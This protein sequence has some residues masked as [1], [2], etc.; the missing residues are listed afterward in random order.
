[1]GKS[2]LSRFAEA[3]IAD[4]GST[5]AWLERIVLASRP[6][7]ERG[8]GNG[9]AFA[10]FRVGDE[11]ELSLNATNGPQEGFTRGE[12]PGLESPQTRPAFV[13]FSI[14]Q[15]SRLLK[16]PSLKGLETWDTAMLDIGEAFA[17]CFGAGITGPYGLGVLFTFLGDGG[18]DRARLRDLRSMRRHLVSTVHAR[19]TISRPEDAEVVVSPDGVLHHSKISQVDGG[20]RALIGAAARALE[21]ARRRDGGTDGDAIWD[22][23]LAGGWSALERVEN[24]GKRYLLLARARA[25]PRLALESTEAALLERVRAGKSNKEMASELGLSDTT[26]SVRLRQALRKLRFK[27]AVEYLRHVRASPTSLPVGEED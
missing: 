26:V 24:D 16:R 6:I 11:I 21:K 18:F 12:W 8:G 1:M 10:I 14:T 4:A 5:V 17:D 22:E 20:T 7:F 3:C 27:T 2:D 13:P 25:H 19:L 23:L 15:A 9:A